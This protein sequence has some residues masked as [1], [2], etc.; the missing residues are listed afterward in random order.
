METAM[1]ITPAVWTSIERRILKG[2]LSEPEAYRC[3]KHKEKKVYLF[4]A[5]HMII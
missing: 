1:P 4:I 5:M 3:Y 2:R